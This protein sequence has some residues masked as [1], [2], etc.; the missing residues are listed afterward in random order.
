MATQGVKQYY[1]NEGS[2]GHDVL[3]NGDEALQDIGAFIEALNGEDGVPT[4]QP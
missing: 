3:L 4:L 1:P 2:N